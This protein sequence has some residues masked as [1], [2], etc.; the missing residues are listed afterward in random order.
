MPT[1]VEAWIAEQTS[2]RLP[3]QHPPMGGGAIVS[4]TRVAA[5]GMVDQGETWVRRWT[6]TV[7]AI[8]RRTEPAPVGHTSPLDP[9]S[10]S[11]P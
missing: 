2:E 5:A 6:M 8:L 1:L 11:A 3:W 9:C 4:E 10:G 7:R